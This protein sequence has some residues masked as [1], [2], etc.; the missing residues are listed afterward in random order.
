MFTK[1][2]SCTH[3]CKCVK[4]ILMKM[5]ILT[6]AEQKYLLWS[7]FIQSSVKAVDW[8]VLSTSVCFP[9]LRKQVESSELKNQRL[10]EVF[11]KKIQEFRTVCYVLTGYQIDLTTENQYR[12]TSVYA[13]HMHDSLLFKKVCKITVQTESIIKLTFYYHW[14][15]SKLVRKSEMTQISHCL[16]LRMYK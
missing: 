12:L 14:L 13:E 10:K 11:Q 2:I 1:T 8:C 5:L 16:S 9:E 15:P 7:L 4:C 6:Q 3:G